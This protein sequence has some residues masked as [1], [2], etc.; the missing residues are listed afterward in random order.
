MNSG[1]GG[2]V[3][4]I[5]AGQGTD[6]LPKCGRIATAIACTLLRVNAAS[7]LETQTCTTQSITLAID[8]YIS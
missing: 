2:V 4:R 1:T 6:V 7:M 8:W 3:T 5:M